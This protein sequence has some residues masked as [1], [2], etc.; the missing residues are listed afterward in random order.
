MATAKQ[1]AAQNRL[2]KASKQA[3]REGKKGAAFRARVKQLLKGTGSGTTKKSGGKKSGGGGKL[4]TSNPGKKA[5]AGI[6]VKYTASKDVLLIAA[7]ATEE[8]L[9][10]SKI[11]NRDTPA[12]KILGQDTLDKVG[13]KVGTS[14]YMINVAI[15]AADTLIDKRTA[16]NLAL[17]KGSVTAWAPEAFM[18]LHMLDTKGSGNK[19]DR[20]AAQAMHTAFVV[21]HNGYNPKTGEWVGFPRNPD[22]SMSQGLIYRVMRHGLQATRLI[23]NRTELGGKIAAPIKKGLAMIGARM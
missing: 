4:A 22:G 3:S 10:K 9:E 11:Q 21:A 2:A 18:L 12:L 8:I 20:S 5:K 13:R 14:D 6:G 23:A 16:H 7:P 15:V 19:L 17:S 1:K